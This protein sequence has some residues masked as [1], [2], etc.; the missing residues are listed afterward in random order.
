MVIVINKDDGR[1]QRLADGIMLSA[2]L[3]NGWTIESEEAEPKEVK[4]K[5][6]IADP[7]PK[8]AVRRGRRS[9]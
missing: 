2:F 1:R 4:E 5:A 9:K 6:V 3:N 8:K 7:E